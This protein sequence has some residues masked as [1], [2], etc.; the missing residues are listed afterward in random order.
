[1]ISIDKLIFSKRTITAILL[2]Y[3]PLNIIGVALPAWLN[4]ILGYLIGTILCFAIY[5]LELVVFRK[6]SY[7]LWCKKTEGVKIIILEDNYDTFM[8]AADYCRYSVF[9]ICLFD[10]QKIASYRENKKENKK[11][12]RRSAIFPQSAEFGFQ[13]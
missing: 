10:Y 4:S 13:A 6:R 8:A 3:S 1:M 9:E 5:L 12:K 2:I 11:A 7:T